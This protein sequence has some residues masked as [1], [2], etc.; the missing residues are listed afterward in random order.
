LTRVLIISNDVIG[1]LMA[2][3]GIRFSEFAK[4]LSKG[5]EVCLAVPNKSDLMN[6]DFQIITYNTKILKALAKQNDVTIT[7]GFIVRHFPFLR[8]LDKPI[9]IDVYDPFV[10]ENILIHSRRRIEDRVMIHNADLEV[11]E[12]QLRAGVFLSALARKKAI[13]G[14]ECYLP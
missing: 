8:E 2:G 4:S 11:L 5:N 9:V 12:D 10:L 1:K 7:H 6:P 14:L 13:S 3:P